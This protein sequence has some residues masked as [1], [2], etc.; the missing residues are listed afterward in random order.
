MVVGQ[1]IAFRA[2]DHGR[3]QA[4]FHAFLAWQVLA[5]VAAEQRIVEHRVGRFADHFGRIEVGDRRGGVLH[6]IGVAHWAFLKAGDQ[7]RLLQ[8]NF[9][10][11][12]RQAEPLRILLDDQ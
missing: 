2:H 9:L 10:L 11:R 7:W 4:R 12:L 8:V 6:G 5:E 1:Q 3:A